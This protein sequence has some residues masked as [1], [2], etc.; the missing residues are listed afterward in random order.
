[1]ALS[2][3]LLNLWFAWIS[4]QYMTLIEKTAAVYEK[5]GVHTSLFRPQSGFGH[6]PPRLLI[7]IVLSTIEAD[8]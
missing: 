4:T 3:Y 2:I 1:M 8:K 5:V 6:F 7:A